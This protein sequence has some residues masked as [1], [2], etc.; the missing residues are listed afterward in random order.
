MKK[1]S[2]HRAIRSAVAVMLILIVAGAALSAG[3]RKRVR[4]PKGSHSTTISGSVIRGE[5]DRYILGAKEG[6]TMTVR[7]KSVEDNAVFQIY[8]AGE[9]ESLDG[10]GEG[11]DATSWSGKLPTTTDYVIVVGGTRGNASYKLEI[12][13]E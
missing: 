13:I 4:F 10:A 3:I 5:Q 1:D 11:D 8:F 7:I 9:Q 6:Q 2:S 12:K